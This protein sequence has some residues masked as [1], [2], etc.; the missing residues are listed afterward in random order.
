MDTGIAQLAGS[1]KNTARQHTLRSSRAS[2]AHDLPHLRARE[3]VGRHASI[4]VF[5]G[6][7]LRHDWEEAR[8]A[9]APELVFVD[10]RT[11]GLGRLDRDQWVASFRALA[12]LSPDLAADAS[13]VLAVN[14]HGL[15]IAMRFFGT[16]PDGGP[17][18]NVLVA[19]VLIAGDGIRH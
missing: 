12:E 16:V 1:V 19:V 4:S 9:L 6:A 13:Q 7:F 17:F 14:R 18:E 15:V 11:L 5:F 8:Q 10:H 3:P 2:S